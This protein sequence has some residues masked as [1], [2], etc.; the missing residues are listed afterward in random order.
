[1]SLPLAT[2][3]WDQ[4]EYDALNRV[5]ASGRFTM[6]REVRAFEEQ[7]AAAFGA[8]Y[9]VMVNSGSSA[10]LVMLAGLRYHPAGYLPE[11]SE[12]I[13]PAC[14]WSTTYFPIQ[15]C[16][17][18]L[19]FVDIDAETLNIDVEAVEAAITPRTK[20]VLAVN[21]LGNPCQLDQ[22]KALCDE[23]GLVLIEDNCE[24]MGARLN[25]RS[26]GTWGICGSFSTFFS[27]HI[28]TME[29]G[30]VTTDDREL[31]HTMVSLRAH[32]WIREQ[33]DDSH[34]KIDVDDFSRLF[35]F[36]LPGYNLRPLEMSGALGQEQLL[37]LPRLVA[38][39]RSNA[40]TFAKLFRNHPNVAIQK[41]VGDSSWFGFAFTLRGALEGRRAAVVAAFREAGIETR[42]IVGG[43][44]LNNPAIQHLDYTVSGAVNAAQKIDEDGL[45]IG[46]HHYDVSEAL[47]R[48]REIVDRVGAS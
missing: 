44:F 2:E 14:S 21:L 39:R 42:P 48:C 47:S 22:L 11:G 30:V 1:M 23:R 8:K 31:Y 4:S 12:V 5:I 7:F 40:E 38:A 15:Q 3:T 13:V 35:R 9:A 43:N 29:G 41:E 25:G 34:L 46:N 36:V 32:G 45:F 26:T 20:A 10:N 6:G 19:R 17:L 37:K 33:P 16:G 24:S 18:A 28:S 27:H